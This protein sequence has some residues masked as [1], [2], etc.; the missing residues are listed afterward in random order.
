MN[1]E[2][3][4]LDGKKTML[5]KLKKAR[6]ENM[7]DEKIFPIIDIINQSENFYTSSS[8]A[9][10]IALLELPNIGDKKNAEFLGKWHRNIESHELIS[11]AS[12]AK[13]G[14]LWFLAQ[15]PIIHI[16]AKTNLDA[17]NMLKTAISSGFK[18]SGLKSLGRKIVVEICSTERL[19]V[20]VG[21]NSKLFCSEKYL[22]LLVEIANDVINRSNLK[23][24]RL[25][26]ELKKK[27]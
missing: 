22:H 16:T 5:T 7:V 10:R 27:I 13:T 26:N 15:S 24:D 11:A 18:N 20:P 21:K 2:K 19:D 4:F 17:E 6:N 1:N 8:C 23:I 14:Q 25:T 12:K 9:G 3:D